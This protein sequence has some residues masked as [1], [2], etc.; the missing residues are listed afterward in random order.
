[1]FAVSPPQPL[2]L[3][4]KVVG[5]KT[6]AP[7][8]LFLQYSFLSHLSPVPDA[9]RYK[10][11]LS[12]DGE[13]TI[14]YTSVGPSKL[15]AH[16]TNSTSLSSCPFV[17]VCTQMSRWVPWVFAVVFVAPL[18]LAIPG[19]GLMSAWWARGPA[20]GPYGG[21]LAPSEERAKPRWHD[22]CRRPLRYTGFWMEMEDFC[23]FSMS[24]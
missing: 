5:C 1:M 22:Y 10:L 2:N 14:M 3:T 23:F 24:S 13:S 12:T 19:S 7:L 4:L 8:S 9:W 17:P 6:S 16:R 11:F 18:S 21:H 15:H 20:S